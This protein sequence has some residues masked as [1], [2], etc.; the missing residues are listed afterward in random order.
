MTLS[1]DGH[2]PHLRLIKSCE[3]TISEKQSVECTNKILNRNISGKTYHTYKRKIYSHNVFNKQ[4]ESI[5]NSHLDKL[6]IFYL[7]NDVG[8]K[9]RTKVNKLIADQFPT[10]ILFPL[11]SQCFHKK[12][13]WLYGT[14]I[15]INI[16]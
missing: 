11:Q 12:I 6:S 9:A 8:S 16:I 13:S 5:Y 1:I 10:K 4:K 2:R 3:Y 7:N 15:Q 14:R